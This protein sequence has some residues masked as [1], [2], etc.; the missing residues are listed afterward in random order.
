MST[1]SIIALGILA[2]VA[3]P[4]GGVAFAEEEASLDNQLFFR[5]AY[6][7]LQDSRGGEVF[8]DTGGA[9]GTFNNDKGGYSVAAGL[10]LSAWKLEDYGGANL[11]GEIFMEYSRF[12]QNAVIQ[13]TSA[14]LGAPVY[15]KVAVTELNVTVAP[16]AR[17]DGLGSGRFRPY[18]I[19][20]GLSFLVN[21][22][23]SDDS[24][25]LDIGLHFGGGIDI[26]VIDRISVGAD[27]RYT[28]GFQETN[29]NT[30]YW[31][32]GGYAALNF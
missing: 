22:P 27:A 6:S 30:R 21:S 23:P 17:F 11:M 3:C 28:Y 13:T 7:S 12:S 29:T 5:G 16:K 10:D 15:S 9:T 32:V 20:I 25:Y 19:P 8:T 14:L 4:L 31:S 18:V 2:L 26:V 1:R 24:T